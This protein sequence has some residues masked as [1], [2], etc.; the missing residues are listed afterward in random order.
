MS[1]PPAALFSVEEAHAL[2]ERLLAEDPTAPSDLAVTYLDRLTTW[3]IARNPGV[4]P[5]DCATAAGDALLALIKNPRTY[6]PERQTQS[7]ER[8]WHSSRPMC[9][10]SDL[11]SQTPYCQSWGRRSNFR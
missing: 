6:K 11:G 3:L 7:A 5:N 2:Y 9:R 8:P 1:V 4:H 10:S